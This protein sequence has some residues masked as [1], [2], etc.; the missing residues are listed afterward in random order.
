MTY[1]APWFR[2]RRPGTS[3]RKISFGR[4]DGYEGSPP[5]PSQPFQADRQVGHLCFVLAAAEIIAPAC[6]AKVQ[7]SSMQTS[8]GG[9]NLVLF[10]ATSDF[11]ETVAYEAMKESIIKNVGNFL[12]FLGYLIKIR[13][14]N[15]IGA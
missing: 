5:S 14:Q 4:N 10:G 9:L 1:P 2:P 3:S 6:S 15:D 8:G 7:Q 11:S 13:M 12:T